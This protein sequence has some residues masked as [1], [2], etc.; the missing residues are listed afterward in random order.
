MLELAIP[1]VFMF[2]HQQM[3]RPQQNMWVL[4]SD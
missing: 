3:N 1:P 2:G 4:S